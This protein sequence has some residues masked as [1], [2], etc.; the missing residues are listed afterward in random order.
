MPSWLGPKGGEEW[1]GAKRRKGLD[2]R[3][4]FERGLGE[5]PLRERSAPLWLLDRAPYSRRCHGNAWDCTLKAKEELSPFLDPEF[6][7]KQ[8]KN[9]A[10]S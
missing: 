6:M 8:R 5:V 2:S 1:L 7:G 9:S 3:E 10:C 4:M